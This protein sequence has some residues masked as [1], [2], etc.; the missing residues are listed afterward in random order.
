MAHK[1][2]TRTDECWTETEIAEAFEEENEE[3]FGMHE[4]RGT[5]EPVDPDLI[6]EYDFLEPME[7]A[8][9]WRYREYL[10]D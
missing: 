5:G 7:A 3:F 9:N 1:D 10:M 6:E 4:E 8:H 2:W